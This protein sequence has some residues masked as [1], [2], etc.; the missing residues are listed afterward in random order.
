MLKEGAHALIRF[1]K[2]LPDG[3]EKLRATAQAA[4]S[5]L[6][7]DMGVQEEMERC[8]GDLCVP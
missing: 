7:L 1:Y 8:V 6:G 3:L 5:Q 2:T 4:Q